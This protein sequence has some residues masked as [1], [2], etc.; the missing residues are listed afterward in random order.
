VTRFK[1]WQ[2][3]GAFLS[4]D[5]GDSLLFISTSQNLRID[6]RDGKTN[7]TPKGDVASVDPPIYAQFGGAGNVPDFARAAASSMPSFYRGIGMDQ[8]PYLRVSYFDTVQWQN[9]TGASDADREFMEKRL[10]TIETGDHMLVEIPKLLAPWPTYDKT[11]HAK[12]AAL[13]AELGLV[14]EAVDYEVQN[15]NR[16][17]VIEALKA[18]VPESVETEEELITA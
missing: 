10:Q 12:I 6:I 7:Y 9:E 1:P 8:D 14:D 18:I 17:S 2:R 16:T 4:F 5:R 11:H 13:A 3:A 15:K